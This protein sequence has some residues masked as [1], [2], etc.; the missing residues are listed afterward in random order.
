MLTV[1]THDRLCTCTILCNTGLR[2]A[3]TFPLVHPHVITSAHMSCIGD[4]DI[5]VGTRFPLPFIRFFQSQA[6]GHNGDLVIPCTVS[7]WF[8]F[9]IFLPISIKCDVTTILLFT[10][11]Y[12]LHKKYQPSLQMRYYVCAFRVQPLGLTMDDQTRSPFNR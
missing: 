7:V 9:D 4:R 10:L 5:R 12:T 6:S 8:P 3:T 1:H 11:K 2:F